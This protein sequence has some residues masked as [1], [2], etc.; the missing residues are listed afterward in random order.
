MFSSK[1]DH[2]P[3][4]ELVSETNPQV[5]QTEQDF[6]DWIKAGSPA[7]G[8]AKVNYRIPKRHGFYKLGY[9]ENHIPH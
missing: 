1:V 6:F 9:N 8:D 2:V 7:E 3:E 4:A 5:G